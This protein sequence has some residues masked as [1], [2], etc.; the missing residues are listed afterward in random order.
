MDLRK[1]IYGKRARAWLLNNAITSLG[2]D[3]VLEVHGRPDMLNQPL[4]EIHPG[5]SLV[6]FMDQPNRL[7]LQIIKPGIHVEQGAENRACFYIDGRCISGVQLAR[8]VMH[9]LH[10]MHCFSPRVLQLVIWASNLPESLFGCLDREGQA[11]CVG[12]MPAGGVVVTVRTRSAIP[13]L[14]S[15][16]R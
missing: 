4:N 12:A 1:S 8:Q 2:S 13:A 6:T 3:E 10:R 15:S 5:L 9:L 16:R 7:V 14:T 11:F